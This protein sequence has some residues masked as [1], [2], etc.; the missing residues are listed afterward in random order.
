MHVFVVVLYC[1][2]IYLTWTIFRLSFVSML[3][4][5]VDWRS[6]VSTSLDP[7]KGFGRSKPN[8]PSPRVREGRGCDKTQLPYVFGDCSEVLVEVVSP[9]IFTTWFWGRNIHSPRVYS[10]TYP[11]I[12]TK[13]V[14]IWVTNPETILRFCYSYSQIQDNVNKST[15]NI[16]TINS[17]VSPFISQKSRGPQ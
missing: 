10:S 14:L 2:I 7:P 3:S 16:L 1:E 4:D 15:S 12:M 9:R 5:T 13:P 17:P 6:S 11:R 8:Q